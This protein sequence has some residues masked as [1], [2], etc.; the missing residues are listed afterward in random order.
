MHSKMLKNTLELSQT[1]IEEWFSENPDRVLGL[2]DDNILWIGS[3]A[4]QFYIGKDEVLEAMKKSK[5]RHYSLHRI[6]TGVEHSRQRQRILRLRRQIYMHSRHKDHVYAGGAEG[7]FR[8]EKHARRF[9]DHAHSPVKY[10]ARGKGRRG[11]SRRGKQTQLYIRSEK[12][13]PN[14]AECCI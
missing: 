3:T 11:F 1:I 5:H 13:C 2:I 7:Y 4:N 10:N 12:S 6:R 8:V 14:E 9:K